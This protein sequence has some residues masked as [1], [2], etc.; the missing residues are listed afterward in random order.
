MSQNCVIKELIHNSASYLPCLQSLEHFQAF[1]IPSPRT[2]LCKKVKPYITLHCGPDIIISL[3][4][5]LLQSALFIQESALDK[6]YRPLKKLF[7]C[8]QP[9]SGVK[10]NPFALLPPKLLSFI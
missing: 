8:F 6:T 4:C 10:C 5:G 9:L 1:I 7:S 3:V 2:K